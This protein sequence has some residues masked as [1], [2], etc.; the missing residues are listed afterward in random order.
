MC[1]CL[2]GPRRIGT[3]DLGE[4]PRLNGTTMQVELIANPVPS[5]SSYIYRDETGSKDGILATGLFETTC[6]RDLNLTY[7]VLCLIKRLQPL[8]D[9]LYD[10][11]FTNPY[12]SL[13]FALQLENA[14]VYPYFLPL[15]CRE[16]VQI[17]NYKLYFF[18]F[19]AEERYVLVK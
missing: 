15:I 16:F 12:G 1:V 18:F 14:G 8:D 19:F 11:I 9:G 7:I 10:V 2:G 3:D 4:I 17:I 6:E 5:V 13:V